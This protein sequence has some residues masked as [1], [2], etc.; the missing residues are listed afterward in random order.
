MAKRK[1]T[2]STL[3]ATSKK[4]YVAIAG[5]LCR[6]SASPALVKD[7]ADYLGAENPLFKHGTFVAHAKCYAKPSDKRRR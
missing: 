5:I 7:M 4:D 2:R 6:N 3:G 1:R